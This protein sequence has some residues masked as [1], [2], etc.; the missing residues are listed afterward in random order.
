MF[1][2]SAADLKIMINVNVTFW[3]SHYQKGPEY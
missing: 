2:F 3:C 1:S